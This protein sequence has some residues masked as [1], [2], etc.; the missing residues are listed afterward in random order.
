[1]AGP[2]CESELA[3]IVLLGRFEPA[4][5]TPTWLATNQLVRTEEAE[6]ATVGI[7]HREIVDFNLGWV[8]L[9]VTTDRFF[10]SA[11]AAHELELVDLVLGIFA[12]VEP[13]PIEAM[14]LNR[15]MSFR[16]PSVAL[17]HALGHRL[18]PKE[19]WTGILENPGMAG[20]SVQGRRAGSSAAYLQIRVAP[21]VGAQP[22]VLIETNEHFE[23]GTENRQELLSV[24]RESWLDT[25]IFARKA[26]DN[27]VNQTG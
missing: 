26:A 3:S 25:Q 19:P 21:T 18:A 4:T 2:I 5:L 13:S 8:R 23:R 7:L 16:M 12:F 24:L 6:N 10:A 1:M 22:T 17:W 20:V 15:K 11:E 14:G 27:L 9:L